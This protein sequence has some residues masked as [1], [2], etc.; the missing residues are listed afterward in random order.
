MFVVKLICLVFVFWV[1]CFCL[2]LLYSF[3]GLSL[4]VC[5][6]VCVCVCVFFLAVC[7]SCWNL[8]SW[9][10]KFLFV[11]VVCLS[12]PERMGF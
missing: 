7:D 5:C 10:R 12:S 11:V 6:W 9:V 1:V 8:S 2:G 4:F 3:G